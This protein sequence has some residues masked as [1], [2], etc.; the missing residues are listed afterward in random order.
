MSKLIVGG[1]SGIGLALARNLVA[2]GE[3]VVITGRDSGRLQSISSE[4]GCRGEICDARSFAA[5]DTLLQSVTEVDGLVCCAGSILL[6]PAHLTSEAE[7]LETFEQNL[8]TAFACVRAAGKHFTGPGSVVLFSTCAAR[9][10]L[11]N[12]EAVA[13]A[14][15]AVEGLTLSAAATYAAKRIRFN[16]VAPG[17]V[18]TPLAAKITSRL[19]SLQASEAQHPLGRIGTPEEVASLAAWLLSEQASWVTGQVFGIDGGL[20]RVK[21]A[22]P[23]PNPS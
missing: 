16:A 4:L 13:A 19:A 2:Q 11:P 3:T 7:L 5:V 22:P 23:R 17:L 1:T 8:K 20:S 10:G 6:K 21:S 18:D 12:H 15:A 9:I 14:K